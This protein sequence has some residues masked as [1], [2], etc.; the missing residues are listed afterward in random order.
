MSEFTTLRYLHIQT[1]I[2]SFPIGYPY[3]CIYF[4]CVCMYVCYWNVRKC[5]PTN[6][7]ILHNLL[8]FH[9]NID[10]SNLLIFRLDRIMTLFFLSSVLNGSIASACLPISVSIVLHVIWGNQA[11]LMRFIIMSWDTKTV[12][13]KTSQLLYDGILVS[14]SYYLVG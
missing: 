8:R 4:V 3:K 14:K 13:L 2:H 5:N 6:F 1:V 7:R 9:S 10:G 11:A 12:M